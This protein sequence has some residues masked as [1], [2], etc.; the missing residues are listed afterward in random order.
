MKKIL[1]LVMSIF[2]LVGCG[3]K[4]ATN[5]D[6]NKAT[7]NLDNKFTNMAVIDKEELESIY[8]LDVSKFEEYVIKSNTS[9]NGNFYA[10]IKVNSTNKASVKQE[11]SSMFKI[12]EGQST[13]YSPESVSL[14]KNRLETSVGDYLIY[15]VS[16]DNNAYYNIVKECIE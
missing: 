5:L 3:N 12:L 4:N 14:I 9:R 1:I 6:I 8:N 11:M 7:T 2:I 10:I 13:L 15:I 16:E